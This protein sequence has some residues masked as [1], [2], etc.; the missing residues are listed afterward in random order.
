MLDILV[1]RCMRDLLS[2]QSTQ[3]RSSVLSTIVVLH[4]NKIARFITT[5]FY[6]FFFCVKVVLMQ[7]HK[8]S[9]CN[10]DQTRLALNYAIL[11]FFTPWW[12]LFLIA[13]DLQGGPSPKNSL[14]QINFIL[15]NDLKIQNCK[16]FSRKYPILRIW[17]VNS[18]SLLFTHVFNIALYNWVYIW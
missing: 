17:I 16:N 15:I 11:N 8:F 2:Y 3:A 10:S 14:S 9:Y 18:F 1:E 6:T 5:C 7:I 13:N 4:P 12:E